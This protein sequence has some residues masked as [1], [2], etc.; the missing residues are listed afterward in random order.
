MAIRS[1]YMNRQ[2]KAEMKVKTD[3][4]YAQQGIGHDGKQGSTGWKQVLCE[5]NVRDM[6][7]AKGIKTTASM[8]KRGVNKDDILTQDRQGN[9]L[10]LEVKH[11][12]GALAYACTLGI[13][14]FTSRDRD[15][16]LQGVDWVIYRL[17]ADPELKRTRMATEYRVCSREDFLDILEEYCHGPKAAGFMTATKFAKDGQQINIQSQYVKQFWAGL[18]NDDRTMC[19][20]DFCTDIL[21][22]DPR[23]DW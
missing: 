12:A 8:F 17:E 2:L 21:G 15:L 5:R 10:H 7:L 23:W 16:C 9:W 6:V 22:R 3:L 4:H 13:E 14:K 11:G 18:Q 1:T 20:W 19:L